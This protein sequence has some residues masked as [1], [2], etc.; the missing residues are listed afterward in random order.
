MTTNKV[1]WCNERK[2]AKALIYEVSN[3]ASSATKLEWVLGKLCDKKDTI[4]QSDAK[5]LIQLRK[6]AAKLDK[7]FAALLE[8]NI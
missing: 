1:T 6:D 7:E 2:N 4:S 8:R 3:I 5:K